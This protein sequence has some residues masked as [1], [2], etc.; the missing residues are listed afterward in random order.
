MFVGEFQQ[1]VAQNRQ[2]QPYPTNDL[3]QF[4]YQQSQILHLH[5]D[6]FNIIEHRSIWNGIKYVCPE[7]HPL[8]KLYKCWFMAIPVGKRRRVD[9]LDAW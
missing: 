5:I 8:P 6:F 2:K 3:Q 7:F 9:V 1:M 4:M